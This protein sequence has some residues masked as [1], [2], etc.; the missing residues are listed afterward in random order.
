MR[1]T[2]VK[3]LGSSLLVCVLTAAAVLALSG[4]GSPPNGAA[5]VLVPAAETEDAQDE[6]GG[7]GPPPWAKAGTHGGDQRKHDQSW[8]DAWRALTPAQRAER[9]ASLARAHEDGM[10]KWSECVRAS[11]TDTTERRA[12]E[13]PL[14]P[15]LA[16][17]QPWFAR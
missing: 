14:P 16:K 6:G 4:G 9:M 7:L 3:S 8:K 12:C 13:K 5:T 17:K 15:G 1:G 10:R 11:G 2:W